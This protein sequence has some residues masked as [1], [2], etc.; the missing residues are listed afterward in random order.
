MISLFSVAIIQAM[1][2]DFLLVF[3]S[4]VL[5]VKLGQGDSR[6]VKVY[7]TSCLHVT[8]QCCPIWS[9]ST[10]KQ[11]ILIIMYYKPTSSMAQLICSRLPANARPP[12]AAGS[13]L[14]MFGC[15]FYFGSF[16]LAN[17]VRLMIA[18]NMRT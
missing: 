7:C 10:G 6:G 13:R 1:Q 12:V 4:S 8:S 15:A 3:W 5:Q 11:E 18:D 16:C 17:D 2:S 14:L 9:T